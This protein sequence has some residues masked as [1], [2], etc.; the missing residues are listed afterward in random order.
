MGQ[1]KTECQLGALEAAMQAAVRDYKAEVME[2]EGKAAA[3]QKAAN[4]AH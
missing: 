3:A 4:E 2:D 1:L